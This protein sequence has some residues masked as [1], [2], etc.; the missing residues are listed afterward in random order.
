MYHLACSQEAAT[1]AIHQGDISNRWGNS[2]RRFEMLAVF[3]DCFCCLS[4][5]CEV[6]VTKP[7]QAPKK[8]TT[9]TTR[10]TK[11]AQAPNRLKKQHFQ[12]LW[13]HFWVVAGNFV[14]CFVKSEA[15][16]LHRHQKNPKKQTTTDTGTQKSKE[17]TISRNYASTSE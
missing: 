17:N 11:P 2:D 5:F 10:C 8:T 13:V 7:A 4:M 16:N 1:I 12:E 3:L 6:R 15:P 9:T 14:Q